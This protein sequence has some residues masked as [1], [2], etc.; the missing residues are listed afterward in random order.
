[1]PNPAFEERVLNKLDDIGNDITDLKVRFAELPSRFVT[2][3][4][5]ESAKKAA[6]S[7]RRWAI[8]IGLAVFTAIL[9]IAIEVTR[10]GKP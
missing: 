1:M 5:V 10:F 8:G 9:P 2:R 3:R 7:A 6:E 4:E